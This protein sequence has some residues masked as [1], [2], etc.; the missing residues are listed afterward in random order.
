MWRRALVLSTVAFAML[1]G[2][3][4]D[5]GEPVCTTHSECDTDS[6]CN[7]GKCATMQAAC[8]V[9]YQAPC[10]EEYAFSGIYTIG[11]TSCPFVFGGTSYVQIAFYY[12]GECSQAGVVLLKDPDDEDG[13]LG[14]EDEA[15][16]FTDEQDVEGNYLIA[17]D[18]KHE[19]AYPVEFT[20]CG[21]ENILF[22]WNNRNCEAILD[23][24]S[25]SISAIDG[26][27]DY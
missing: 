25:N 19:N 10:T 23:L 17:T 8:A 24:E 6:F 13:S 14:P 7:G 3:D 18:G 20:K 5:T 27:C 1:V 9:D 11:R 16:L 21:H 15:C 12:N 4:S 26:Y 2:C 22:Q